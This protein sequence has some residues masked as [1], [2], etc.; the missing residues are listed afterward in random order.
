MRWL[1]GITNSVDISLSSGKWWRT[2]KPGELQ[3]IRSQRVGPNW[4]TEQQQHCCC[5]CMTKCCGYIVAVWQNNFK[6]M[7]KSEVFRMKNTMEWKSTM[8][9]T[10]KNTMDLHGN[11]VTYISTT[12]FENKKLSYCWSN[13]ERKK[14]MKGGRKERGSYM[15]PS[16]YIYKLLEL[17]MQHLQYYTHWWINSL[18]DESWSKT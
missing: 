15:V 14:R 1:D 12:S 10:M 18:C 3:S 7:V 4:V 9:N 13:K 6:R 2:G 16:Q 5:G 17:K 11:I 8:K